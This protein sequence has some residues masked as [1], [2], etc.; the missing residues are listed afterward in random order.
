MKHIE[1]KQFEEEVL[2][3]DRV[4][5]VV[6]GG[7]RLRFRGVVIVGDKHGKIGLGTGKA[8]DVISAVSK[9][10]RQAKK[11]LIHVPMSGDT[12]PHD[13]LIKYKSSHLLFMPASS[14]TGII[15]GGVMRKIFTLAG[16]KNILSKSFGTSNKLLNAQATFKALSSMKGERK[17][18]VPETASAEKNNQHASKNLKPKAYHSPEKTYNKPQQSPTT[19]VKTEA[20]ESSVE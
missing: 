4:T 14:G 16:Y 18:Y 11:N 20:S 1:D 15:A 9:A 6:A 12:I 19:E 13:I 3:I 2:S 7:R 8:N 5:R 17:A 10:S